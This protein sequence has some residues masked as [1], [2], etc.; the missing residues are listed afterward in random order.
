MQSGDVV[1]LL[2]S[3]DQ[4]RR[5]IALLTESQAPSTETVARLAELARVEASA[6]VRLHLAS[7]LQRMPAASRW[8]V[9][10]ALMARSEDATDHNLPLMVWYG[11]EPLAELD[12]TRALALAADA[13]LPRIFEFT[14][15][16]IAGIGGPEAVRV[17]AE[18]LAR[19][20]NVTQQLQLVEGL[21]QAV[22]G[23]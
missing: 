17:L 3:R 16:R 22:K 5:A 13:R 6:L 18:R 14:V 21:S 12:M 19:T 23:K 20:D 2:G 4:I 11:A 8:D 10:A 15:R 9:A 7:A 1:T